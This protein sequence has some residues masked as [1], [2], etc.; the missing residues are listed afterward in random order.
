M[1]KRFRVRFDGKVL[2]PTSPV[3]LPTDREIELSAVIDEA[4][5][6]QPTDVSPAAPRP[7]AA[8]AES[9][10]QLPRV[11]D[12]PLPSDLA[13]QHDHYLYGTPRRP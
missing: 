9:A 3:D 10:R 4:S 13:A 11:D 5:L 12:D 2:I 8:L 7:L 6:V 1:T